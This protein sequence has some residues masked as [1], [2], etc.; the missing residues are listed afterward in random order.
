[1]SGA[2]SSD[3]GRHVRRAGGGDN[4][5]NAPALAEAFVPR[6]PLPSLPALNELRSSPHWVCWKLVT[7]KGR[8]RKMPYN[9]RNGDTA[10]VSDPATWSEYETAEAYAVKHHMAGV[11]FVL[12]E[13]S[14]YIGIDLDKCVGEDGVVMPWAREVLDLAE[15]YA[16]L[17]PSGRGIHLFARGHLDGAVKCDPAGVELYCTSRYFTVTGN[18][19]EGAPAEIREAPK[20]VAALIARMAQVRGAAA[21]PAPA[22]RQSVRQP[23]APDPLDMLGD[24]DRGV[25]RVARDGGINFRRINDDALADLSWVPSI[26]P[27]ARYMPGTHSY[28]VSS[29]DLG[30][31]LEE[32]LSI[33]SNGIIDFGIHDMGDPRQGR[34]TAIDVVME[35]GGAPD[36]VSAARWLASQLGRA[37]E[38]Y[39]LD[40]PTRTTGEPSASAAGNGSG[41]GSGDA[42]RD[43]SAGDDADRAPAFSDEALALRFADQHVGDLRYVAAW[44][45]SL[46]WDGRRWR[47]DDTW[48][49]FDLARHICR[50]AAAEC[51]M[52]NVS[53][54]LAS[55]KTVAAVERLAKADRRLAATTDQWDADPWLLNTP[56]GVIDLRTGEQR[57]HD[58]DDY[59]TH[60]TAVAPG[61]ACP[62]WQDFL[63][64][65]TG[66]DGELQSFL[67]R[68]AGYALTGST[69]EHALF[70]LF[71][72]GANGKSVFLSTIAG[73][74][75]DYHR[76]AAIETFVA[77]AVE[78]HPTDLASLRGA[79]L[80]TATETEEGRRW[81]EARIKALTG[82]DTI[83]ARFMR[84]DFF[85][86]VPQ[87][88][89]VIAGNHK[90][91]LRSVDEAMRRRLNLIPFTVTIP[92]KER[93]KELVEKLRAEWPGI[94]QWMIDGCL[95]WQRRDGQR[96]A[97]LAAPK[98]VTDATADYLA[99]EDAVSSWI[100]ERCERDPQAWEKTTDLFQ[101]WRFWAERSG[102]FVGSSKALHQ[103]LKDR[104]FEPKRT[105]TA[106]GFKG[107]N[108]T[109]PTT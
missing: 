34:R 23:N 11:G 89:L 13:D 93:D 106:K 92:P 83:A 100:E 80:V 75:A 88:K 6:R 61:G 41:S 103:K 78:R 5:T 32:D 17:S 60:M 59:C 67:R 24:A 109:P 51:N 90:P 82:G 74:L 37:P 48:H 39:G 38:D 25:R 53:K 86:F 28:R 85:E 47:F 102:E 46:I 21:E 77:S 3:V 29:A 44:G 35:H 63:S 69:A 66:G 65:V 57:A 43:V 50:E 31:D 8:V 42:K 54:A 33:A 62:G 95:D 10:S 72:T 104:G 64:R 12:T 19:V 73:I 18:H 76:T 26:F 84:Q 40:A 81:A 1:M 4:L 9:G 58:P 27:S 79:R 97:G 91:G 52:R 16:E 49:A 108:S 7:I 101:S 94:L 2:T 96:P 36:A 68:V 20:T 99:E 107:L 87:F 98:I 56:G 22:P 55:G 30:R 71:G 45:R 70:F 105:K 14:G 15:T